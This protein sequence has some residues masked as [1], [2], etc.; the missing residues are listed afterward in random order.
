MRVRLLFILLLFSYT[1]L[2]SETNS[3]ISE[4]KVQLLAAQTDSLKFERWLDLGTEYFYEYAD[5]AEVAID[6]S[7]QVIKYAEQI[8]DTLRICQGLNLRG[9]ILRHINKID[10]ALLDFKRAKELYAAIGNELYVYAMQDN[11]AN[12][13]TMQ[14]KYDEA[15][16]YK[17]EALEGFKKLKKQKSISIALA[18]IAY[19][20][21]EKGDYASAKPY[22]L[23][24][25]NID[26]M[27]IYALGNLGVIYKYLNQPDSALHYYKLID[28]QKTN[29]KFDLRNKTNMAALLV[30]QDKLEEAL[31]YYDDI[32]DHYGSNSKDKEYMYVLCT[33]AHT[34]KALKRYEEAYELVKNIKLEDLE[35]YALDIQKFMSGHI[36]EVFHAAGDYKQSLLF[37]QVY[38]A[39]VDSLQ[40]TEKSVRFKEVEEKY[41]SEK[42]EKLIAEQKLAIEK[43]Q[44][45]NRIYLFGMIYLFLAGLTFLFFTRRDQK[46][47]RLINAQILSLKEAEIDKLQQENQIIAMES[48]MEG[49]E[50]ERQRIARDLHDNIGTLMST[51]KVKLLTIQKNVES[52]EKINI[53]TQLDD[54]INKASSEIRRISHNMTPVALNLTGLEGALEDL[55]QQLVDKGYEV[56]QELH[57]LNKIDDRQKKIMIFR[58]FQEIVQNV[59]KHAQSSFVKLESWVDGSFLN[60]V[61]KDNGIGMSN[62]VWENTNS[63]GVNSIKSRVNYLNGIISMENKDGTEFKIKIPLA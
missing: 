32:L 44:T 61:I 8:R 60:C 22:C 18:G 6:Y 35:K 3:K 51:I 62:N 40:S 23:E 16:K 14:G 49:Q 29:T 5:S 45:Q 52:I 17:F 4:L 2:Y 41:S 19:T 7:N 54:M 57:D 15:L 37:Y 56:D 46:N 10:D 43:T 28:N 63:M 39:A 20:Y 38:H 1:L 21:M 48:I 50:E 31:K 11:Y 33:K 9:K 47:K 25:L 36:S 27:D 59:E 26:S 34:L 53:T 24:V 30:S 12:A 13:L 55:A 58:I 42:K